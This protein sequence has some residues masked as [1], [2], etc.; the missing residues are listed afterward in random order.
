MLT[1]R[2]EHLKGFRA[3]ADRRTLTSITN[4]LRSNGYQ[5]QVDSV[6]RELEIQDLSGRQ[7]SVHLNDD[8][9]PVSFRTIGGRTGEVAYDSFDRIQML[10]TP[11]RGA[12]H[13][14]Y[15]RDGSITSLGAEK[16]AYSFH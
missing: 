2:E 4:G 13:F 9:L 8:D 16:R 6:R 10:R 3:S 11:G 1:I 15:G 5:C 14:R 7:I 12:V